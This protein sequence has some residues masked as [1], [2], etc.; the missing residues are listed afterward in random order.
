MDQRLHRLRGGTLRLQ[1]LAAC[2]ATAALL[3]ASACTQPSPQAPEV[4]GAKVAAFAALGDFGK[5]NSAQE[6]V[7]RAMCSRLDEQAFEQVVTT[8]DNIYPSG[9][10]KRFDERFHRP[11]ECVHADGVRFHAV[12]GNHDVARDDGAAE[13][14][15]PAFG[16]PARYYAWTLGPVRFIMLDSNTLAHDNEQ[17]QWMKRK[18]EAA[19]DDPWTV[20][21]FHHPVFSAGDDHG[22]TPGFERLLERPFS[23]LGVDL[24]LNGHE[25]DYQRG[26]SRGVT[27]VVTGGG[28]ASLDGCRTP[29]PEP[30]T[31]CLPEHHFVAVQATRTQL[32]LVAIDANGNA[33][34]SAEISPNR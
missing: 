5:G 13:L 8:G 15:E 7:A 11:Y 20:V 23:R 3:T 17:L 19:R 24:V 12:L 16:M 34:H 25:H 21:V 14:N 30:I 28:G 29:I 27:Y 18:L 4:R 1:L 31:V 26:R 2:T 10:A 32:S 6:A 33:I 9:Q 22:P